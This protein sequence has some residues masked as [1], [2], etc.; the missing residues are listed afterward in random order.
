MYG[1][2]IGRFTYLL[3]KHLTEV[4]RAKWFNQTVRDIR[5]TNGIYAYRVGSGLRIWN[6]CIKFVC[7]PL[8]L[9]C[10]SCGQFPDVY[11]ANFSS[12]TVTVEIKGASPPGPS[13]PVPPKSSL[14]VFDS[15]INTAGPMIVIVRDA[16]TRRV[17]SG[18]RI[19]DSA[20]IDRLPAGDRLVIEYPSLAPL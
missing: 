3:F 13:K 10:C 2:D 7:P 8:L 12:R 15:W 17:L 18:Q 4:G 1:R 19:T 16:G 20:L 5:Q 14:V 9:S 11:F 6:L